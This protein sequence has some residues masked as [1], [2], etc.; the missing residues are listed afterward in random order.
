MADQETWPIVEGPLL[1]SQP[2]MLYEALK[3]FESPHLETR[4][5][6]YMNGRER[7]FLLSVLTNVSS[8]LTNVSGDDH[9]SDWGYTHFA[10]FE[11]RN[12]DA[13]C[14]VR[15]EGKSIFGCATAD[16]IPES[17]YPDKWAVTKSWSWLDIGSAVSWITDQ[18]NAIPKY[19]PAKTGEA[20]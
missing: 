8:V 19:D 11:H 4:T 7:G 12:S 3:S 18:L 13:L 10:F 6:P 15:W 5:Q 14:C 9:P 16:D 20:A 17:A 1:S 2:E